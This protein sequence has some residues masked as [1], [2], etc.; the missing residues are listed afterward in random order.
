MGLDFYPRYAD[1]ALG[2]FYNPSWT[3][4]HNGFSHDCIALHV[5]VP[6]SHNSNPM[7]HGFLQQKQGSTKTILQQFFFLNETKKMTVKYKRNSPTLVMRITS[8]TTS[9]LH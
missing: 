3:Y 2:G 8:S 7:K 5:G 9:H 1:F 4:M 6:F